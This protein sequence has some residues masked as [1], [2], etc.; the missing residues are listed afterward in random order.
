MAAA[1]AEQHAML[2][3]VLAS[4]VQRAGQVVSCGRSSS[5]RRIRVSVMPACR[6]DAGMLDELQIIQ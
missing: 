1:L 5:L 6:R 2:Q 3:R 4:Q